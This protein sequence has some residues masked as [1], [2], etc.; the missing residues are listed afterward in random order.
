MTD[1]ATEK[2]DALETAK[3]SLTELNGRLEK[4]LIVDDEPLQQEV[5]RHILE[6]LNYEVADVRSG[7]EAI[8]WCRDNRADL[9]ILDMMMEP[10]INGRETFAQIKELRPEQKAIICSGFSANDEIEEALCNGAGS[11]IKKPYSIA[12]LGTAVK[13]ELGKKE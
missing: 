10:G 9:I 6:E 7:E 12:E 11:Y 1:L 8:A 13:Q 5:A 4:I 2:S 3:I